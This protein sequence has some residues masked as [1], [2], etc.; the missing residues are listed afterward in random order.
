MPKMIT[1]SKC[2]EEKPHEAKGMCKPC[3]MEKYYIENQEKM[4]ECRREW[5]LE[6]REKVLEDTHK[7]QEENPEKVQKHS[8]KYYK[9]NREKRLEYSRKYREENP[10][11]MQKHNLKQYGIT[12][13]EYNEKLK[14]QGG[15]CAVCGKTPEENGRRLAVDH[16]HETGKVRGLLCIGCNVGLGWFEL[17]FDKATEYLLLWEDQK[18]C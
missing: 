12:L 1:C 10:E 6:N 13:T 7:W 3:Y 16:N 9:E 5:Y 14:T 11:K 8:R 2:G 15:G 4:Q 18:L 17:L